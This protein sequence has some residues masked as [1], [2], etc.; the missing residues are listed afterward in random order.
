MEASSAQRERGQSFGNRSVGDEGERNGAILGYVRLE[1]L[2]C[3]RKNIL[4][5]TFCDSE[6]LNPEILVGPLK[7]IVKPEQHQLL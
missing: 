6:N 3:P 7:H 1:Y 4:F 2:Q 5:F